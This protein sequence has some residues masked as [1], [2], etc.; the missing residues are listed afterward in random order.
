MRMSPRIVRYKHSDVLDFQPSSGSIPISLLRKTYPSNLER[1]F[2][3]QYTS[4]VVD[5]QCSPGKGCPPG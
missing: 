2:N 4:T 1:R 3:D 5:N